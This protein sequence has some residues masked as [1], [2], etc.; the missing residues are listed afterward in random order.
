MQAKARKIISLIAA[1]MLLVTCAI[2]GVILPVA[3]ESSTAETVVH[4]QDF[5]G[6]VDWSL[7]NY[8]GTKIEPQV[9]GENHY[10]NC[11]SDIFSPA[12]SEVV[13]GEWYRI[14]FKAR[15]KTASAVTIQPQIRGVFG[16]ES[17]GTHAYPQFK[18]P[19]AENGEGEWIRYNCY[20]QLSRRGT[21]KVWYLYFPSNTA[22]DLDDFVVAKVCD[23][24]SLYG[25]NLVYGGDFENGYVASLDGEGLSGLFAQ[26]GEIVEEPDNAVNNVL[27]MTAKSTETFFYSD[28]VLNNP[29]T[30]NIQAR[31]KKGAI[32][33][34][35]YRQKGMGTT[36]L[37]SAAAV[38]GGGTVLAVKGAPDTASPNEW[39][40]VTAYYRTK[41]DDPVYAYSLVGL[42]T[43]GDVYLDDFVLQEVQTATSFGLD[44]TTVTLTRGESFTPEFTMTPAGSYAP[45]TLTSHNE[46]VVTVDKGVITAVGAGTTTVTATDGTTDV[47][48]MVT[49]N[50]LIAT[51]IVMPGI[52]GGVARPGD[53]V[54]FGV[55]V[56]NSD[57]TTDFTGSLAVDFRVNGAIVSTATFNGTIAA[58]A[59]VVVLADEA[60][61]AAAGE[62]TVTAKINSDESFRGEALGDTAVAR[63]LRVSA[64][65]LTIPQYALD[66]GFV[67]LTFSDDFTT[68]DTVDLNA[69]GEAGYKW[70]VRRPYGA[71]II[72]E[73]E[74]AITTES[75]GSYLTL[76]LRDPS[77]N[78]GL[79][80]V[81]AKSGEG[82]SFNKGYMEIRF[83]I[84]NT[85]PYDGTAAAPAIWSLP[86]EKICAVPNSWVEMD[87]ME[88]WGNSY[89]TITMHDQKFKADGTQEHWYRNSNNSQYGLGDKEWHTMGFLWEEGTITAYMDGVQVMSQSYAA[90]SVGS[91]QAHSNNLIVDGEAVPGPAVQ[92]GVFTGMD[93]LMQALIISGSADS[94]MDVDYVRIWQDAPMEQAPYLYADTLIEGG[95]ISLGAT[96]DMLRNVEAGTTI[97]VTAKPAD[98]YIMKP[99]SLKYVT[100][101]GT[102]VK[103]LNKFWDQN[104]AL[105][106]FGVGDG[107]TFQFPAPEQAARVT[108]EFIHESEATYAADTIG[109]A[110]RTNSEGEKDGIRFLT[111]LN[112]VNFDPTADV[113]NVTLDGKN[114]EI[115]EFGSLLMLASD[116][117]ELT[118]THYRWKSVAYSKDDGM[119]C[120]L[121]H[122]ESY[123]D[124][125]V[126]M[127]RGTIDQ[128]TFENREYTA[129]GYLILED[130]NDARQT[131][132][133]SQ[134]TN[135]VIGA[136]SAQ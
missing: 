103:I 68:L 26:G 50:G 80:T 13:V 40:T 46:D 85:A 114:Y 8:G 47:N 51:E 98:G 89:Y 74:L 6:T 59:S 120:I 83:R 24:G 38:Y 28:Q 79:A 136:S 87:W 64:T 25:A 82:F 57:S 30:Y 52:T 3:A 63:A 42:K 2:S 60:W 20:V 66:A 115:V 1:F 124:F 81:D 78:Y 111:R 15:N 67:T 101:D 90:D 55:K 99:G 37:S 116:E 110:F 125:T 23:S 35:T 127:T 56:R 18:M 45:I 71:S 9:E 10:I 93:T 19:A 17:S 48:I 95:D 119:M 122:T 70:Y 96:G 33:K 102:E 113:L 126:V 128:T 76:K 43:Y 105:A 31:L 134:V 49:V 112:L 121:D 27:H 73:S 91:P 29:S 21:G 22:I 44:D 117:G 135:S 4:K 132:L 69:T 109:T 108:A 75:G 106:N 7:G 118:D 131:I 92:N 129:R 107:Y 97:T 41:T 34:L 86:P 84:T 72:T 16:T 12:I 88:Y 77:S 36:A 62:Y 94:P 65:E 39:K 54:V 130:E 11:S 133:C 5:E 100:E 14:S 58:N 32:Y 53:P 104:E 61:T 123:I